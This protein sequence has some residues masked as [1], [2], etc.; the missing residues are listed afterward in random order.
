[1]H[2][3]EPKNNIDNFYIFVLQFDRERIP[4]RVVHAR[5]AAAKG[6][7]EVQPCIR[8][9]IIMRSLCNFNTR[10]LIKLQSFFAGDILA[11]VVETY[12]L[13]LIPRTR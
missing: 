3:P 13:H 4:E 9:S 6:F 2:F 8:G 10:Q 11:V 1:M 5:G 7:F 12:K